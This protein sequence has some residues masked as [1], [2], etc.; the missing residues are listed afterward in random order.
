MEKV[1]GVYCIENKIN[2]KKYIGQSMDIYK[3]WKQHRNELNN[4]K[5]RNEH[6]QN[7]W[8]TYK[9]QSFMFYIL[10]QCDKDALNDVEIYYIK[11][12]DTENR[13]Y[14]YN[15]EP[16]GNLQK[17]IPIE[18]RLK[19]SAAKS[20]CYGENNSFY[21]K[22]HT[23]DTKQINRETH[24]RENLSAETLQKMCEAQ[25]RRLSIPE[26]N[27]M[28]GKK[29]SEASKLLMSQ[30][31]EKKFGSKNPNARCVYCIELELCFGSGVEGAEYVGI[32]KNALSL[33]LNGKRPFA[34]KH[35]ITGEPLHWY[36]LDSITHQND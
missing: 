36:R 1:C 24:L 22:H 14:G 9:E 23:E 26:N 4:K 5:H 3:R 34:G 7:A 11:L 25:T 10:E 6:L 30:N 19:M 33:H 18:T 29:H 27:P 20:D 35:P 17:T 32:S 8:N 12:F 15:I 21:G 28:F 31:T 16:G 13:D 2:N